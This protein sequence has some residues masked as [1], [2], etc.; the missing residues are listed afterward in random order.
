MK[1]IYQV[2]LLLLTFI[3]IGN[4]TYA[5]QNDGLGPKF[6][7]NFK[8]SSL[9]N[10]TFGFNYVKNWWISVDNFTL[11]SIDNNDAF[12]FQLP[13]MK[14]PFKISFVI[15]RADGSSYLFCS[16]YAE[17]GDDIH[18]EFIKR[19]AGDS[20]FF[21][22][23]GAEKYN[24]AMK[25]DQEKTNFH[26]E[27]LRFGGELASTKDPNKLPILIAQAVD[28]V[29]T[30]TA[31]STAL[32]NNTVG[33]TQEVKSIFKQEFANY[34]S[35]HFLFTLN[36][37]YGRNK[38]QQI[39]SVVR[40]SFNE[41]KGLFNTNPN[42]ESILCPE[43]MWH[44]S[45][46]EQFNLHIN[47]VSNGVELSQLYHVI[48]LKYTGEVRER[49][50]AYLLKKPLS[51]LIYSNTTYDSLV[52]DAIQL[53]NIPFFKEQAIQLTRLKKGA[54]TFNGEFKDIDGKTVDIHSFKGKAVFIDVWFLG[55]GG[56]ATFHK[57]F[58][59]E[60]YPQFKNNKDFVYLSLNIDK[61]KENWIKGMN[62]GLYTADEYINL[63]TEGLVLDHPFIK[64]YNIKGGPSLLLID[65]N[66]KI[67]GQP[68]AALSNAEISRWIADA[69][70][71][72]NEN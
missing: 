27:W 65:K 30:Y 32:I 13:D 56:C 69:M 17:S 46:W 40:K 22:G 39:L 14:K 11:V 70:N 25:M 67:Y 55:C 61:K 4:C 62:S 15:H 28:L 24:L 26:K 50:L 42:Q 59:Q 21:T 44:L 53:F 35:L 23:K 20:I 3:I 64:Y 7:G 47:G 10:P 37:I 6:S 58:H 2:A 38:D 9:T 36:N 60:I 18:I 16:Y 33:T 1:K 68:T 12:K 71:I 72:K 48:K 66:G 29:S 31:S 63:G 19:G 49:I 5:R 43:Y 54:T 34:Y 52:N 41:F 57:R 51:K 45:Q 8:K